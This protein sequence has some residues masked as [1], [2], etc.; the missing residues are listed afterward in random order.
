MR[1]QKDKWAISPAMGQGDA[2][3]LCFSSGQALIEPQLVRLQETILRA[4]LLRYGA[5]VGR[6]ERVGLINPNFINQSRGF[7]TR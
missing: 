4:V 1:N 6:R 7:N 3:R 2:C 5:M